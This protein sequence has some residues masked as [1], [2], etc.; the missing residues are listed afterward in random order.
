MSSLDY[1][2]CFHLTLE[3]GRGGEEDGGTEENEVEEGEEGME[4]EREMWKC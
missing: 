4:G 1:I 3:R 2:S